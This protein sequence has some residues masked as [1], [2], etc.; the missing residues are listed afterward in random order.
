MQKSIV[1]IA[2]SKNTK[3]HL[4]S[5]LKEFIPEY[6][7][8]SSYASE[9]N[10]PDEITADLI[11]Y[12]SDNMENEIKERGIKLNCKDYIISER[13]INFDYIELVANIPPKTEVLL[14]NDEKE[15]AH[16]SIEDLMELGL[17]HIKYYPYYP[18]IE[19]YKKL[20]IA[21][22]PGESDKVPDCVEKVID[23][24]P[25]IMD[26]NTLYNIMDKLNFGNKDTRFFTK[27]YM[28][29]IIN[30]SKNISLVN[31]NVNTLNTYLNNIVDSL[32]NGILVIDENGYIKYANEQMTKLLS[33]DKRNIENRN[34]KNLVDKEA[35]KYFMS[36]DFYENK[37]IEIFGSMIKTSKFKIPNS[38]NVV[39]TT[40]KEKKANIKSKFTQDLLL[41]GHFAK[42]DFEDIIG[43]SSQINE[44]K[45]TALKL[46]KSELTVLIEGESGT[47]KELFASAI[48][49]TS[50]RKDGPFLAVNFS[51][52]PDEL[53]ESEL[54]GYEEGAFTGAKKG[55]KIGLFELADGGT[56][57][58][59]EIG[60]IS[61]KVQTKLL[62]VLQEKEIMPV[63]GTTI[64]SVDVRVIGATNKDL[65]KMVKEKQFRSDLYY[66]L[67]IGYINLPPLRERVEDISE[68]VEYFI[69][70][71]TSKKVK[72]AKEVIDEFENYKWLGN[73]RE[74]ESTIKYMLAVRT[75]E[76]LTLD[77]L[78]DKKFFEEE[79]EEAHYDS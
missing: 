1:L 59:D 62:R 33:P 34:V 43:K 65:R 61:L 73:V 40:S 25:R 66:R 70:K 7:S 57:F 18:G 41:K 9:E 56:I 78:P 50:N 72:I 49:N 24:G 47:G 16:S 77:D 8:I 19:S 76:T 48:H 26:I 17:N 55:G 37:E 20:K 45:L 28:Q 29:K 74:L 13:S 39:I 67:K 58:L 46:S 35:L 31:N 10:M 63:G 14:V 79:L 5:Q 36:A 68:L 12:S 69:A 52:L 6:I 60:D 42:Y 30:V 21:I 23:L 75:T 32:V 11:I 71:E 38:D 54:F 4:Y 27:R 44:V 15:T 51:A 64:K 2:G 53:I 3:D 22:T